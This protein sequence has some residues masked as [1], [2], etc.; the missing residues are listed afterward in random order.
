MFKLLLALFVVAPFAPSAFAAQ[1]TAIF[2]GGCF[3]C[4]QP[5]FDKTP[6]VLSATAGYTGGT[7]DNPTYAEV[8]AGGTGHRESVQVV[9]DDSKV[10]YADL[11]QTFWHNIDPTDAIGQFCDHG[12]QYTSAIFY[13]NAEQKKLAEKT[14]A[15]VQKKLGKPVVT[16]ILPAAKFYPAEDYHQSYYKKN[17]IRYAY[18]RHGCGRDARLRQIWGA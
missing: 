6:G 15:E 12:D 4:M 16:S 9:F 18:Y 5:P 2:A 10:S 13:E 1:Q 14:K 3:W 7:K 11:L 17:P 8:S